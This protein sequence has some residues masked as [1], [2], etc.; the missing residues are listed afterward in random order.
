MCAASGTWRSHRVSTSSSRYLARAD[1]RKSRKRRLLQ[2]HSVRRREISENGLHGHRMHI[3]Q[4]SLLARVP[5]GLRQR[6]TPAMDVG[7]EEDTIQQICS[8][9]RTYYLMHFEPSSSVA[10][11]SAQFLS[12]VNRPQRTR[13]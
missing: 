1:A 13:P 10:C 12:H 3:S 6:L 8:R 11:A 7:H 5:L 4:K 2:R 9:S